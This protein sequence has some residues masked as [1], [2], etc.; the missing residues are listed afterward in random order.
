MVYQSTFGVEQ[1]CW[2]GEGLCALVSLG[3][4]SASGKKE[5]YDEGVSHEMKSLEAD[6]I[7]GPVSHLWPLRWQR[8]KNA[9]TTCR[10]GPI[11]SIQAVGV[12]ACC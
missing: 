12:P 5:R 1:S 6:E 9:F 7:H 8:S 4:D 3:S 2:I 10:K 11:T